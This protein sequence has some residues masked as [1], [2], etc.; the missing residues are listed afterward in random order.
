MF[1]SNDFAIKF[2]KYSCRFPNAPFW[3][4]LGLAEEKRT[5][6]YE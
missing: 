5:D 1:F 3:L 2:W 4:E 6:I